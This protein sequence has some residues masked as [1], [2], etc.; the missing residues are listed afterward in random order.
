[1]IHITIT[2][3]DDATGESES[4]KTHIDP[5]DEWVE[6]RM[7]QAGGNV[8]LASTLCAIYNYDPFPPRQD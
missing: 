8:I 1:M 7:A 2:A 4:W 5:T 3:T 6:M